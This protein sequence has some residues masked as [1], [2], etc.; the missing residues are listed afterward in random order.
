PKEGDV[1]SI[2]QAIAVKAADNS[3]GG[4]A[5]TVTV[6]QTV[7]GDMPSDGDVDSILLAI[8]AQIADQSAVTKTVT[9]YS[10]I[11]DY[12]S[13]Y[14]LNDVE[15]DGSS[16]F[17]LV[18]YSHSH[19]SSDAETD[20]EPSIHH[21]QSRHASG[22]RSDGS[23]SESR[24]RHRSSSS[25][26][27]DDRAS[28]VGKNSFVIPNPEPS[29]TSDSELGSLDADL[30]L[31]TTTVGTL[32]ITYSDAAACPPSSSIDT[33]ASPEP[34]DPGYDMSVDEPTEDL[35][36]SSDAL[37]SDSGD[38]VFDSASEFSTD[39]AADTLSGSLFGSS[40]DSVGAGSDL[41]ALES[42]SSSEPD[43][44]SMMLAKPVMGS[45]GYGIY[46]S[47]SDFLV[48]AASSSIYY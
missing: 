35:S 42:D 22:S 14:S 19:G 44:A 8:A 17:D 32:T 38:Y 24:H 45:L 6:T 30:C 37:V 34:T 39:S 36:E 27:G 43:S 5:R 23:E 46:Q 4:E 25:S 10:T 16:S 9:V 7:T 18:M 28:S 2:M 21:S 33:V 12:N 47:S 26:R 11:G 3:S 48:C 15:S 41:G 20:D 31:S 13:D 29:S 40:S 1:N